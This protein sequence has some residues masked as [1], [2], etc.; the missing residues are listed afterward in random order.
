MPTSSRY[1][2]S[3]EGKGSKSYVA[4]NIVTSSSSS[5]ASE[6][7]TISEKTISTVNTRLKH[8]KSKKNDSGEEIDFNRCC[9]CYQTYIDDTTGWGWV[10]CACSRWLHKECI[11][12]DVTTAAYGRELLCPFC[13][14]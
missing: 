8:K 2:R 13:C 11:Q 5:S 6:D 10:E 9:L 7:E 1:Q 14:T 12:Y 4:K 3:S